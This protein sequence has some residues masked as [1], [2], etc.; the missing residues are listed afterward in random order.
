VTDHPFGKEKSVAR[1]AT[2][3]WHGTGRDG[4]GKL[5]SEAGVLEQASYFY[6]ARFENEKR[7]NP[8]E[9]IVAAHAGCLMM[10]LAFALQGAGFTAMALDR[11]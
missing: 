10:S 6:K 4:D 8:E 9:L 3:V 7:T 2:G 11:G 1:K 5:S